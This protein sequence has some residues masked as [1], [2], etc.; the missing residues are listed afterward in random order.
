M[1]KIINPAKTGRTFFIVAMY[2]LLATLSRWFLTYSRSYVTA[3][4]GPSTAPA[5]PGFNPPAQG[6]PRPVGGGFS[7]PLSARLGL[8]PA[9]RAV[10]NRGGALAPPPIPWNA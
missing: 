2:S 6:P 10:P 5:P 7:R 1:A 8:P 3:R 4:Q 9:G